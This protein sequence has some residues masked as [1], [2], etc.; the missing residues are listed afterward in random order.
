MIQNDRNRKLASESRIAARAYLDQAFASLGAAVG[1]SAIEMETI[2]AAEL[3]A[4]GGRMK[5]ALR[6]G[7]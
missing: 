1:V 3:R 7:R 6:G 4:R 2:P 5:L